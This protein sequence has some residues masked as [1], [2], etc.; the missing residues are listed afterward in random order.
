MAPGVG[1][2][3]VGKMVLG[4]GPYHRVAELGQKIT[5]GRKG[6]IQICTD[7]MYAEIIRVNG[8]SPRPPTTGSRSS[9]GVRVSSRHHLFI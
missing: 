6:L 1:G 8:N 7:Y 2:G 4:D 9:G 3:P 5:R